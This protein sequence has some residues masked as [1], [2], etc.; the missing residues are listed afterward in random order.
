[1]TGPAPFLSLSPYLQPR[2]DVHRLMHNINKPS[3]TIE[4]IDARPTCVN[5]VAMHLGPK[6]QPHSSAYFGQSLD[7][8]ADMGVI[9]LPNMHK[10]RALSF[11]GVN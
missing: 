3:I 6:L 5:V 4:I 7:I 10:S 2:I 11:C 8:I 1:M 9:L